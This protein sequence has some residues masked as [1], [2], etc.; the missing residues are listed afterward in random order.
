MYP[1]VRPII[2]QASCPSASTSWVRVFMAMT[3]GSLRMMPWPRA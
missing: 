2:C 3:V 1:G